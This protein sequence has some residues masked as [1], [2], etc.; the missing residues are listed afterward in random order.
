MPDNY[1]RQDS[2]ESP[3]ESLLA[4]V[5]SLQEN[6]IELLKTEVKN[7]FGL[8]KLIGEAKNNATPVIAGSEQPKLSSS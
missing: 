3:T 6:D 7:L 8:R 5:S 1:S 4:K 2:G